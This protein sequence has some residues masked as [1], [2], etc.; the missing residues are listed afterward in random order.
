MLRH[1]AQMDRRKDI[2]I[3]TNLRPKRCAIYDYRLDE[4]I[5][6]DGILVDISAGG[7]GI[8]LIS[9]HVVHLG[10]RVTLTLP[11]SISQTDADIFELTGTLLHIHKAFE[12]G[13][14]LS[15]IILNVKFSNISEELERKLRQF[16][17]LEQIRQNKS[18]DKR[19]K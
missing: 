7:C 8:K 13:P 15:H 19:Q 10:A 17:Y 12:Q 6:V 2:R 1:Q 14:W 9:D 11:V 5:V 4:E 16:I 3:K 18:R